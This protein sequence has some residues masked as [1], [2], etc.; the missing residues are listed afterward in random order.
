MSP[1]LSASRLRLIKG[2]YFSAL[3]IVLWF[4]LI[5]LPVAPSLLSDPSWQAV[6]VRAH[7]QGWQFGRDIIFTYG[8]WG[9][10]SSGYHLGAEA[11][12]PKLIWEFIGHLLLAIGLVVLIRPVAVWR[13]L[14]LV[15]AV[16]VFH[17]RDFTG[18]DPLF[19][20]FVALA[21]SRG[22]MAEDCSPWA[23]FAWAAALGFLSQFKLSYAVLA[24]GGVA[25]AAGVALA[26]QRRAAAAAM[27]AG[28]GGAFVLAWLAAG[29]A[30]ANLRAYLAT[31]WEVLRGYD[32]MAVD[33]RPAD[34]RFGV[35][36]GLA[37]GI[38]LWR[39]WRAKPASTTRIGLAVFFAMLGWVTWKSGFTRADTW[40]VPV[41]YTFALYLAVLLPGFYF[42]VKSFDWLDGSWV[43]CLVALWT[44]PVNPPT[45][46]RETPARWRAALLGLADG[47]ELPGRWQRELEE[48]RRDL[49]YVHL[50]AGIGSHSIDAYNFN[51][52]ELLLQPVNFVPRPVFQGYFSFTPQLN[53]RN[54]RYYE[55]KAA[56][57]YVLWRQST[58]DGRFPT[59]DDAA[60]F[61]LMQ[62]NYDVVGMAGNCVLL[63]RH[64]GAVASPPTRVRLCR[65]SLALGAEFT[66][67]DSAA[68]LTLWIRVRAIPTLLGRLRG[69]LYKPAQ[70]FMGTE[71]SVHGERN[72]RILPRVTN[73][74]GVLLQPLVATTADFSAYLQGRAFP[75]VRRVSFSAPPR[76]E[77]FWTGVEIEISADS[78]PPSP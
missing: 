73:G 63:K 41:F 33:E 2:T 18:L 44:G 1:P 78:A 46:A 75:P 15:A 26:Q 40:H 54:R 32:G 20:L 47:D 51:Q 30:V 66:L 74:E 69:L 19:F 34:F 8:P 60:L 5:R 48:A 6:L 11:A 38:F 39:L 58:I 21:V 37:G 27:L 25:L 29:Q 65:Q 7:A 35:A 22:L 24:G 71:D 49:P 59:I 9:F 28:G 16:A 64:P 72:W 31:G 42:R 67:P 3:V 53:E 52:T 55:S 10:L 62:Q 76:Q 68:Q 36:V 14:L 23:G 57:D 70:L 77:K 61:P 43:L 12:V 56:P 17:G 4:S 45:L 50:P 13:Q